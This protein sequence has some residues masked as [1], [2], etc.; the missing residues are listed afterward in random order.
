VLWFAHDRD[1]SDTV[2]VIAELYQTGMTPEVMAHRIRQ[3]DF[4]LPI[5][6]GGELVA[7]D[8]EIAGIIDSASFSD[9]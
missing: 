6:I 2:Y 1:C 5:D 7:N 8:A 3:I 4:S 9:A